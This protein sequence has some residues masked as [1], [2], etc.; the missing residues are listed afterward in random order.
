[1]GPTIYRTKFPHDFRSLASYR[2]KPLSVWV[3]GVR[4]SDGHHLKLRCHHVIW[5]AKLK[6]R[7]TPSIK[8]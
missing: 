6:S 7:L 3:P 2:T 1:M 5:E 8:S 4:L